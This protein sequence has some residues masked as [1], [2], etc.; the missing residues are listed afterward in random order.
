MTPEERLLQQKE[1]KKI[2]NQKYQ[3][4]LKERLSAIEGINQE[5]AKESDEDSF[6]FPQ[7]KTNQQ[8]VQQ[9]QYVPTVQQQ[10]LKQKMLEATM[11]SMI[12]LIP[13]AGRCMFNYYNTSKQS[14]EPPTQKPETTYKPPLADMSLSF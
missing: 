5:K 9:I 2:A 4:K 13:M 6:F 7:Q 12:G 10:T 1:K 11:L 8:P 14:Q 3:Q